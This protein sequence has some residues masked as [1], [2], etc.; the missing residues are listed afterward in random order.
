MERMTFPLTSEEIRVMTIFI[1]HHKTAVARAEMA[2]EQQMEYMG[3]LRRRHGLG[4]EW[5]LI[6]VLDGFVRRTDD[7][8]PETAGII[9]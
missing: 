8:P 9:T 6:D 5:V 2:A 3:Q 1:D 7:A 4:S